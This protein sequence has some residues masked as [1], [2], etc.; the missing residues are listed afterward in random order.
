[1]AKALGSLDVGDKIKFGSIYGEPIVWRVLE[2]GHGGYPDGV[3]TLLTD[4]II[5]LKCFDAKET[6][7]SD[8]DRR[9]Y[10]NNDWGTSNL[11]QWLNSDAAAGRWYG[12]RHA[13]DA[14]PT[15]ANCWNGHNPYD[16]AAGFLS[17]FTAQERAAL[18]ATRLEYGGWGDNGKTATDKVFLL[19]SNEVGLDSIAGNGTKF[20]RFTD[21]NSLLAKPTAKAVSES[22]Y[23]NS[24]LNARSNWYWWLRTSHASYS[25]DA[26]FVDANGTLYSYFAYY[27]H[28]GVRPVCNLSSNISISDTT[29]ADGCH[30]IIYNA[31]PSAP[32]TITVPDPVLS[33]AAYAVEWEASADPE[34]DPIGYVLEKSVGGG[35]WE[36]AYEGPAESY[37]DRV[38]YGSGTVQYRVKAR[39]DNGAESGWAQS[40]VREVVDNRLPA[41]ESEPL[42]DGPYAADPPS[43]SYSVSDPEGDAVAVVESM[44]G[45]AVREFE[46]VPGREETLSLGHAAWL[47]V[48]NGEHSYKVEA[49]DAKGGATVAEW[50]W[51]KAV[52]RVDLELAEPLPAD[53]MPTVASVGVVASAPAG[54]TLSIEAC[55]NAYDDEPAWEDVTD[56]ALANRKIVFQNTEKTAESWGVN[57]RV[58]LERGSAEGECWVQS[59]SGNFE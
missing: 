52:T 55:N 14:P 48:P 47:A 36:R 29:D 40:D 16:S 5:T 59:V 45:R 20:A 56:K 25:Y 42:A 9:S 12:A 51:T 2:H 34:G 1:M 24:S 28:G 49:T 19:S 54:S 10:G 33:G 37:E 6:G 27:G 3:T 13:A 15:A 22:T 50:A 46:A 39:D 38:P 23:T 30:A 18:V 17:G 43:V 57:V 8:R 11:R 53:D 35:P 32:A 4:N 44:D 7:N 58:R 26:R 41:I 21:N 31:P